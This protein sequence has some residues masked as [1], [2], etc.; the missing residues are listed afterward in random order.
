MFLI[1]FELFFLETNVHLTDGEDV[2]D[3]KQASTL[4]WPCIAIACVHILD[5][6][7]YALQGN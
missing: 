7:C 4:L 1:L 6:L 3:T 5:A 2:N